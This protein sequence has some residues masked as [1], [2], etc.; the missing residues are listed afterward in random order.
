VQ[1]RGFTAFEVL[2]AT[3]ILVMVSLTVSGALTAGRQASHTAENNVYAAILARGMMDEIV[4]FVPSNPLPALDSGELNR[5]RNDGTVM[6]SVI[7]YNSYTDGAGT[8]IPSIKDINGNAYPAPYQNFTRKVTV[9]ATNAQPTGWTL[10]DPGY[11]V[12]VTVSRNG[13]PDAVLQRYVSPN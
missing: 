13:Q 4:R 3:L 6:T 9:V 12:T 7:A 5:T 10:A 2:L 8:T 1:R 11:L